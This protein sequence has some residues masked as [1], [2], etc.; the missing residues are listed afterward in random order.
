YR[1]ATDSRDA[2]RVER[3]GERDA[4]DP[5][6][7]H[8][9]ERRVGAAANRDVCAFDGADARV[10]RRLN[11]VPH[12]RRRIDPGKT[13]RIEIRVALPVAE[14]DHVQLN[15]DLVLGVEQPG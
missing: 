5:R 1:V 11:Q 3:V 7:A 13:G 12:V 4:V 14:L 10:E 8:L 2:A 9:F 6:R 15:T